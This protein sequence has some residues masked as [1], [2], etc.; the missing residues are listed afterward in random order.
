MYLWQYVWVC[1]CTNFANINWVKCGWKHTWLY[2][3]RELMLAVHRGTWG[4]ISSLLTSNAQTCQEG[5]CWELLAGDTGNSSKPESQ[6]QS[7]S[8][9]W[10]VPE[11]CGWGC[12]P[13]TKHIRSAFDPVMWVNGS[14]APVLFTYTWHKFSLVRTAKHTNSISTNERRYWY[15]LWNYQTGRDSD[16]LRTNVNWL[17]LE[18]SA[19]FI[20][21]F[22]HVR[23][24][25]S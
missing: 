4:E 16:G 22:L 10:F 9:T 18:N 20:F 21:I 8:A 12:C 17:S 2:P 23:V 11:G 15:I 5:V 24:L 13:E 7:T 3:H 1:M 19:S 6:F 14:V 25:P